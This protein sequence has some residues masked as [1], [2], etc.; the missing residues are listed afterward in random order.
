[1]T[2]SD[3]RDERGWEHSSWAMEVKKRD[4]FE[5]QICGA[6][7]VKLESHHKNAWSKYPEERYSISNGV[8]LCQYHHRKFHDIFGSHCDQYQFKQYKQMY[9]VL[10]KIAYES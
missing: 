2:E 3:S 1:M 4:N 7:G 6:R 9:E 10:K 8:T 5:C